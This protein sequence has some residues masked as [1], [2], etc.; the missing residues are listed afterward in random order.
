M[1]KTMR[2]IVAT[3]VLNAILWSSMA[4]AQTGV[5]TENRIR[6]YGK[7]VVVTKDRKRHPGTAIEFTAETIEYRAKGTYRETSVPLSDVD[8]VRA[9][10]GNHALEG[11][12]VGGGTMALASLLA[13]AEVEADPYTTTVDNAGSIIAGLIIGGTVVGLLIGMAFPKDKIVYKRGKFLVNARVLPV[14]EPVT[15]ATCVPMVALQLSF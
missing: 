13:L 7:G 4:H 11:A 12:L 2:V 6:R 5:D 8:H 3:A 1:M 15:D 14:M 10:V 9:Q